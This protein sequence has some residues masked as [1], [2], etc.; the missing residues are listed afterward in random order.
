MRPSTIQLVSGL[1]VKHTLTTVR[2]EPHYSGHGYKS[3]GEYA[4][5]T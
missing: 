4:R 1:G 5:T 2:I 3:T